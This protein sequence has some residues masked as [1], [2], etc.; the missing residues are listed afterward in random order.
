MGGKGC[1]V[2]GGP[3][4]VSSLPACVLS[5]QPVDYVPFQHDGHRCTTP[6]VQGEGT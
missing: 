2:E 4:S 3:E 5:S 6:G 1:L